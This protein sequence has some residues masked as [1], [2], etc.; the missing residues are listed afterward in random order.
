MCLYP[1][2]L[3]L[4]SRVE[5][6]LECCAAQQH[7][8]LSIFL[9]STPITIIIITSMG[10]SL[11]TSF[12]SPSSDYSTSSPL[13]SST[14][15]TTTAT[16][17]GWHWGFPNSHHLNHNRA[18]SPTSSSSSPSSQSRSHSR[19]QSQSHSQSTPSRLASTLR[20]SSLALLL[21]RRP[22]KIDLALSEERSR[23]DSD[24][25]ERQGLGLMEPR[26]V[27]PLIMG[28]EDVTGERPSRSRLS[29]P[30]FVMGGIEEV[31]EGKA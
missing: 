27:D 22:S 18:I 10:L 19:S 21:R 8:L 5:K 14:S 7:N 26:P 29:Q 11:H 6:E 15:T 16:T 24:V 2:V 4:F 20:R 28:T 12:P 25:V 3:L 1:G 9:F 13:S 30:V 31:M 17:G 23:A